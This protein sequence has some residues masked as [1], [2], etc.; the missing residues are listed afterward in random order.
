[1]ATSLDA[2]MRRLIETYTAGA[3]GTVDADG[4]PAV[5]PK[6]TFVVVDEQKI[7]YGNLRSPGTEANIRRDPRVEVVFV[8]VLTRRAVRVRGKATSIATDSEH[9]LALRPLFAPRWPD[10]VDVILNYVVIDIDRVATILSPAY[11]NGAKESELWQLNFEKLR[12]T[13]P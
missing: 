12:S 3:V 13:Q 6:A 2:E 11:D 7:A 9:G 10:L 8:D 4:Y 5:S 1:M